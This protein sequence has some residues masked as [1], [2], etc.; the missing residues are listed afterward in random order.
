[1]EGRWRSWVSWQ[2]HWVCGRVWRL[3]RANWVESAHYDA[4]NF[5]LKHHDVVIQPWLHSA[6]LTQR[7]T[8]VIKSKVA[9]KMLTMS[10]YKYR[11][12]LQWAATRY[13]GRHVIVS[14]EPGTSKTCTSCGHWNANLGASETFTCSRCGLCIGRDLNGAIGNFFAAYGD[15]VGIGWDG[16]SD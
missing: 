3:G 7:S 9:R 15:A 13:P 1:M 4:A 5:V 2:N 10:H 14:E 12:R 11:Q 16:K 6:E 8:R